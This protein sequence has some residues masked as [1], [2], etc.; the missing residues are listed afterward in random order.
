MM[1]E[2]KRD[3]PESFSN[4]G[5]TDLAMYIFR[6][7]QMNG[8]SA[9]L[10]DRLVRMKTCA[11]AYRTANRRLIALPASEVSELRIAMQKDCL[12]SSFI[13]SGLYNVELR[14]WGNAY[15]FFDHSIQ[16]LG[17]RRLEKEFLFTKQM[18]VR[19]R[20]PMTSAEMMESV[21]PFDEVVPHMKEGVSPLHVFVSTTGVPIDSTRLSCHCPG[22]AAVTCVVCKQQIEAGAPRCEL[23][24]L[25]H[26]CKRIHSAHRICLYG[27]EGQEG[28]SSS[29]ALCSCSMFATG[30]RFVVGHAT[31]SRPSTVHC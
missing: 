11:N 29:P 31:V 4:G 3:R 24:D 28:R 1:R 20:I 12:R 9:D 23:A 7:E 2:F 14:K 8:E 26:V 22:T 6:Q 5:M 15:S 19:M 10:A 27:E 25:A 30:K 18:C 13:V 17:C 16:N 21:E